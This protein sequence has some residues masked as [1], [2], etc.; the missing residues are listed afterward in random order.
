MHPEWTSFFD[1]W[2]IKD[3]EIFDNT[4]LD[5]KCTDRLTACKWWLLMKSRITDEDLKGF[6]KFASDLQSLPPSS[7]GKGEKFNCRLIH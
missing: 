3:N 7:A 1:L 5:T 2:E 4:T 6:C